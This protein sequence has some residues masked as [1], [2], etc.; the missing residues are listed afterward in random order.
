MSRVQRFINQRYQ[1][2]PASPRQ[3]LGD[4]LRVAV[5]PTRLARNNSK[6]PTSKT[7]PDTAVVA[8]PQ[9]QGF[10]P[11]GSS[12][13][14]H[15]HNDA[16]D[17][18][19][20]GLDDTTITS[21]GDDSRSHPSSMQDSS[22]GPNGL[23]EIQDHRFN[24]VHDLRGNEYKRRPIGQRM[25]ALE[26]EDARM[27]NGT[28]SDDESGDEEDDEN[29]EG[30]EEEY[31]EEYVEEQ[32][33]NVDEA[34]MQ[35]VSLGFS[36]DRQ[37]E[38]AASKQAMYQELA[39]SP[40]MRNMSFRTAP[41]SSHRTVKPFTSLNHSA[42][43]NVTSSDVD[44]NCPTHFSAV[45]KGEAPVF[46]KASKEMISGPHQQDQSVSLTGGAQPLP[47][48]QV[49]T[50]QGRLGDDLAIT[51]GRAMVNTNSSG[52]KMS[53]PA[54]HKERVAVNGR[55]ENVG[56]IPPSND[57]PWTTASTPNNDHDISLSSQKNE[58]IDEL[59][60]HQSIASIEDPKGLKRS[61]DID[62]SLEELSSMP[63]SQ[64]QDEPF[65]N[66]PKAT[67]L[68]L[69]PEIADAPLPQKLDYIKALKEDNSTKEHH[70]AAFFSSL[71][72]EQYEDCGDLIVQ[73]FADVVSKF[74]DARQQRRKVAREFEA[75]VAKRE[76]RVRGKMGAV[77]KDLGRLRRG[78]EEVVRG[79]LGM[80]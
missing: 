8:A 54:A 34:I 11:P 57:D 37:T 38:T 52:R 6:P 17:T 42:G 9:R 76:E 77:E 47:M 58:D 62:Y 51:N 70:R 32:R 53:P 63:F 64:L 50:L 25:N 79:K 39:A 55:P 75:E 10:Q 35:Q 24:P 40:S 68:P 43:G 28:E 12:D 69:P 4:Q 46:L 23:T 14:E 72:I 27:E 2:Q 80:S 29:G 78:G 65:H 56:Q 74:K 7:I 44:Q 31:E 22:L 3:V 61:R 71:P 33:F 48:P 45:K 21:I 66:D 41:K 15:G 1:E 18:D 16:F 5:A 59:N 60:D 67:D 30:S 13:L 26:A 73:K 20:E 19:V 36:Q 49:Q